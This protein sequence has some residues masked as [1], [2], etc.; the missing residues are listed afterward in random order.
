MNEENKI[1][2]RKIKQL[3]KSGYLDKITPS[4]PK[5]EE[6]LNIK[7][8]I[9]AST[10]IIGYIFIPLIFLTILI[11]Q[12]MFINFSI[13]TVVIL[14]IGIIITIYYIVAFKKGYRIKI[15]V[16]TN[17]GMYLFDNIVSRTVAEPVKYSDSEYINFVG[18]PIHSKKK[19]FYV[20]LSMYFKLKS[21]IDTL[22]FMY[23][24]LNYY[25]NPKIQIKNRL[26]N[27]NEYDKEREFQKIIDK[28]KFK[29]SN[30]RSIEI[31]KK[32]EGLLIR[33]VCY[34]ILTFFIMISLL[35]FVFSQFEST[36][37]WYL[38][39]L[40]DAF[41]LLICVMILI[42]L[43]ITVKDF[44]KSFKRMNFLPDSNF[45]ICSDGIKATSN[46]GDVWFPFE[47]KLIIGKYDSL[48]KTFGF[49]NPEIYDGIEFKRFNDKNRLFQ[50]GPVENHEYFYD[51]VMYHYLNWINQNDLILKEEQI[52]E[53][54]YLSDPFKGA[55]AE[56]VM[57]KEDID[58][59]NISDM[60]TFYIDSEKA[61]FKYS[62][63]IYNRYI[64]NDE[65]IYYIH[66]QETSPPFI[67]RR[68]LLSLVFA[69]KFGLLVVLLLVFIQSE[70]PSDI[71]GY[72]LLIFP[73]YPVGIM[74]LHVVRSS[75][76][77]KEIKTQEVIFTESK[78][79]FK[80]DA[81]LYPLLY[82][83][84]SSV[85]KISEKRKKR[86]Y[87][88]LKFHAKNKSNVIT[89]YGISFDSPILTILDSKCKVKYSIV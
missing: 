8:N 56:K 54:F 44:K 29:I 75:R 53:K 72:I 34:E 88:Y 21:N 73:L 79:I 66:Q 76:I 9:D 18:W 42:F 15:L 57:L 24:L 50:V 12:T 65:K 48:E 63:E 14:V 49:F 59:P 47:D 16:F 87:K 2:P 61:N 74:G 11:M 67:K 71:E 62:K 28:S 43:P 78:I 7:L 64:P 70:F 38:I 5:N 51:I 26:K 37:E 4:I 77:I 55:I 69:V 89:L 31:H 6:I 46:S 58:V 32:K 35:L 23:F 1:K 41:I 10:R 82:D 20:N 3:K 85:Y 81:W 52:K 17:I 27:Q 33:Y 45:E 22:E 80:R 30:E 13:W 39:I 40:I 36:D 84:I 83:D 25:C 86:Y 60:P 68:L 19:K